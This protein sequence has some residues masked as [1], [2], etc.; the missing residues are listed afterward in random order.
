MNF[1]IVLRDDYLLNRDKYLNDIKYLYLDDDNKFANFN[2]INRH[3][4]F[5]FSLSNSLLVLLYDSDKLVCMV[6]GYLYNSISNDWALFSLFTKKDYRG[7][8]LG[9]KTLKLIVEEI[10]KYNPNMIVS[11]IEEDNISS[12]KVHE[13]VGFKNSFRKWNEIDEGFP[14]NYLA[15]IIK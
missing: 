15:F 1:K 4:D 13:S 10:K 7:N 3:L 5:I 2:E 11:G 12:I 6:N 9:Y 8:G 14:D